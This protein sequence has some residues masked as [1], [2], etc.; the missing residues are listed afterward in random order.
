[1]DNHSNFYMNILFLITCF[2]YQI[3][4][5]QREVSADMDLNAVLFLFYLFIAEAEVSLFTYIAQ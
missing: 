3:P 2:S 1:M 4:I 5:L